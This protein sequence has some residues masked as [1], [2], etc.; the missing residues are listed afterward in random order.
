M[1]GIPR[2]IHMVWVGPSHLSVLNRQCINSWRF[3]MPGYEIIT[4]NEQNLPRGMTKAHEL[5][6]ERALRGGFWSNASNLLRL[7]AIHE[8]GGIY[9]DTDMEALRDLGELWH[10]E[11]LIVGRESE[12]FVN[13]AAMMGTGLDW[14]TRECLDLIG[15][16]V[17]FSVWT[18]GEMCQE[19]AK[20]DGSEISSR[21]GPWLLTHVLQK[22]G[23]HTP[24]DEREGLYEASTCEGWPEVAVL[25]HRAFYPIPW[26]ERGNIAKT[27]ELRHNRGVSSTIH[28]WEG[29]WI[30]SCVNN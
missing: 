18:R 15:K 5:Y 29:T 6:L 24:S 30:E 20:L 16:E 14:A 28:H 1:S 23:L 13:V 22:H 25:G 7:L 11:R 8:Y 19:T 9:L 21:S 17:T 4:W 3:F 27:A 10:G 2:Q 12:G 26:A